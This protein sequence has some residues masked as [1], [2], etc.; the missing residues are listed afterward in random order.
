MWK[1]TSHVQGCQCVCS[2]V[3][4]GRAEEEVREVL[5]VQMMK[6]PERHC[7]DFGFNSERNGGGG[8]LGF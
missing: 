3:R 1:L 7:E 6:G 5:G 8:P 4:D 2:V